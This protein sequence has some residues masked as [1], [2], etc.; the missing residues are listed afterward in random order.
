MYDS[1]LA[2]CCAAHPDAHPDAYG[3]ELGTHPVPNQ[4]LANMLPIK[5]HTP[6][7]ARVSMLPIDVY[8]PVDAGATTC[9]DVSPHGA[10]GT[11][12]ARLELLPATIVAKLVKKRTFECG[13]CKK[14]YAK[15]FTLAMHMRTAHGGPCA[16]AQ[17]AFRSHT[18]TIPGLEDWIDGSKH[19]SDKTATGTAGIERVKTLLARRDTWRREVQHVKNHPTTLNAV[20]GSQSDFVA[21]GAGACVNV[22]DLGTMK[23]RHFF[24]CDATVNAISGSEAKNVLVYGLRS[25]EVVIRDM[26]NAGRLLQTVPTR[27]RKIFAMWLSPEANFLVVCSDG[28]IESWAKDHTETD[29]WEALHVW[30]NKSMNSRFLGQHCLAG[31][32]AA[33]SWGH[34]LQ[35]GSTL[36]ALGGSCITL[37][38]LDGT[39]LAKIP[40][41]ILSKVALQCTK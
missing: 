36:L 1:S 8:Q 29:T 26:N 12:A 13:K 30:P 14:T 31:A 39:V 22:H 17:P 28:F 3:G 10:D 38:T 27:E 21:V 15:E 6:V 9:L 18:G 33:F 40:R 19:L 16:V 4:V 37:W 34:S 24:S 23:I 35:Y 2:V 32:K 20:W 7:D 5:M 41:Y 11:P 25:G